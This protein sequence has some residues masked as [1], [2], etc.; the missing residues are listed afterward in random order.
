[1]HGRRDDA[2]GRE[3]SADIRDVARPQCQEMPVAVERQLGLAD[4]V[5]VVMSSVSMPSPRSAI[6]LTGR[7]ILR[8]AHS[9]SAYSG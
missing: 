2:A 1:M 3:I 5:A 4:M 6:H 7:P 8:E 9:A